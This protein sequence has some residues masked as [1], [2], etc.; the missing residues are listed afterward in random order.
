MA[1]TPDQSEWYKN[2]FSPIRYQLSGGSRTG[3]SQ[4]VPQSSGNY[5]YPR[6]EDWEDEDEMS[7]SSSD[8]PDELDDVY[9]VDL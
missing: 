2:R 5:A 7:S 3:P 4:F 1:N 6:G 8:E 9:F